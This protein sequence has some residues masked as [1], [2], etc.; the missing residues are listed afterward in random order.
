MRG[1]YWR[2]RLCKPTVVRLARERLNTRES[3]P[4]ADHQL[5]PYLKRGH[6]KNAASVGVRA[7]ALAKQAERPAPLRREA[8]SSDD[9]AG[10]WGMASLCASAEGMGGCD[11]PAAR[12]ARSV[13]AAEY[14]PFAAAVVS[15]PE[16][17]EDP[18]LAE[19][20]ALEQSLCGSRPFRR[21]LRTAA[22]PATVSPPP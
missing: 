11:S 9:A 17:F 13:R 1:Y 3:W 8:V 22:K 14:D 20:E 10:A 2:G 6:G 19:F 5:M 12:P 16:P 18:D 21:P 7:A 4:G 15:E